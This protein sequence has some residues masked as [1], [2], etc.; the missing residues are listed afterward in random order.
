MP[1]ARRVRILARL[2]AGDADGAGARRLCDVCADVTDMSGAGIMVMS[3]GLAQGS[4]CATDPVSELIEDLQFTLGEGPCV[5]AYRDARPVLE[6]D[7]LAPETPRWPA[8]TPAATEAGVR[9]VFGFPLRVGPVLLGALNLYRDRSGPLGREEHADALAAADL[10]GE[11]V[12]TM[13]ARAPVGQ[14]ARQLEPGAGLRLVVHQASGMVAAQL[15]V[16]VDEALLRLRAYAFGR[17]RGLTEVARDV[18]ARR[19]RFTALDLGD[20]SDG[21]DGTDAQR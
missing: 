21:N 11:A 19:L 14:L 10:V 7:L 2:S 15:E 17:E 20:D 4:V 1:D 8:F 9:A 3:R 13:Q 18:V 5:D 16:G 12:L 6:P